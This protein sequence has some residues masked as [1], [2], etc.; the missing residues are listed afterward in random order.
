MIAL[1]PQRADEATARPRRAG[2]VLRVSTDRQAQTAEG[3]LH[4]QRQR[5]RQHIAY[6]RDTVGESWDEVAIYE[7]RAVSG[8]DSL[9]SPR[10]PA[11]L[12][13][14]S[15]GAGDTISVHRP[16]PDLPLREGL[17][18]LLRGPERARRRVRLLKQ[19]YDTTTPKA[20]SS[21]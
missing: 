21:S 17:P 14:R 13:G 12:R 6:K 2:L 7:L 1:S 3:S 9:R 19:N 20:G 16:R 10:V 4:T 18:A 11:T 15:G 5:L 8:K